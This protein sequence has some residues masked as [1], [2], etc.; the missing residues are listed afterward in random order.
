MLTSCSYG[1][2]RLK[3]VSCVARE[4]SKGMMLV[5]RASRK[6]TATGAKVSAPARHS[7][8]HRQENTSGVLASVCEHRSLY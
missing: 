4:H 2:R 1:S 3:V 8:L 7:H 5:F 6:S